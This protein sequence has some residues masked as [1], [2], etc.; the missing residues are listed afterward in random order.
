M[1]LWVKGLVLGHISQGDLFVPLDA[2]PPVDL[3]LD[4]PAWT[5]RPHTSHRWSPK[6][7]QGLCPAHSVPAIG[8][9]ANLG[10]LGLKAQELESHSTC[11]WP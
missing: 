4:Q 8:T 1:H 7:S 6:S 9:G 3:P 11:C 5:K 2:A 10:C